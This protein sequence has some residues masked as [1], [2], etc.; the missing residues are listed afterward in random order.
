MMQ[1]DQTLT[2]IEKKRMEKER[3]DRLSPVCFSEM[4]DTQNLHLD[5]L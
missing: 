5:L 4:L 1:P 2:E 3:I